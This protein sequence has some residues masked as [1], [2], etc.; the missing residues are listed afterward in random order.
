MSGFWNKIMGSQETNTQSGWKTDHANTALGYWNI[1][2][3]K[4]RAWQC[5]IDIF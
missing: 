2:G 4:P 1:Y 5:D 3:E